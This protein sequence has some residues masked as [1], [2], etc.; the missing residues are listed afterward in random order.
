MVSG[1][2]LKFVTSFIFALVSLFQYVRKFHFSGNGELVFS[3]PYDIQSEVT[4]SE[5]ITIRAEFSL[6]SQ[7]FGL[8][9]VNNSDLT[10][11]QRENKDSSSSS[12]YNSGGCHMFT[13]YYE[14]CNKL[15]FPHVDS[16]VMPCTWR[17]EIKVPS[18]LVAISSGDLIDVIASDDNGVSIV[19]FIYQLDLPVCA[20]KIAVVVGDFE[21]HADK[22]VSN[23][24][25]FCPPGLGQIM[26]HTVDCIHK[27]IE[28]MEQ[29]LSVRLP[30]SCF[31]AVFVNE[32][33][34]DFCHLPECQ[35]LVWVCCIR[36][37][38]STKYQK[39]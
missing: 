21:V 28:F 27:I 9:F 19:T 16:P 24:T 8:H 18:E 11:S 13:Y 15:W 23:M 2:I 26:M 7:N 14:N 3:V 33:Y 4:R 34:A 36:R 31:K 22:Y 5:E 12:S 20:N 38:L 25:H 6:E 39:Q 1:I 29:L 17:I 35:F 30:F 32:S 37:R 10:A